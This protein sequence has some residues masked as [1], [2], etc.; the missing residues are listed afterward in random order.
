M[1]EQPKM[2]PVA[3]LDMDGQELTR[4]GQE[5]TPE[6]AEQVPGGKMLVAPLVL[7]LDDRI[8]L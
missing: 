7:G 3:D 4:E 5:L 8:V 1:S 2:E 6:E